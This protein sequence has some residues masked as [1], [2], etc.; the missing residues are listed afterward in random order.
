[1]KELSRVL[2]EIWKFYE[3]DKKSLIEFFRSGYKHFHKEAKEK[4]ADE[5]EKALNIQRESIKQIKSLLTP[6]PEDKLDEF[7]EKLVTDIQS[8][9]LGWE[10]HEAGVHTAKQML[11]AYDELRRG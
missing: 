11:K 9:Y 3:A 7:V 1:M 10:D 8:S 5:M 4:D 2:E 6:I